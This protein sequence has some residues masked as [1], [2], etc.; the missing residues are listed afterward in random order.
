MIEMTEEFT[1]FDV[2]QEMIVKTAGTLAG[3]RAPSFYEKYYGIP[4]RSSL[5][6]TSIESNIQL[7]VQLLYEVQTLLTEVR[8]LRE[9]LVNRPLVSSILLN[10]LSNNELTI[11]SPISVIIEETNEECLARW[12]EVNAFGI[13]TTLS[14]AIHNL[15]DN[16]S[17]LYLDLTRR[18]QESLGEIALETLGILTSH[19]TGGR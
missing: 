9:E 19:I 17:D 3:T 5:Q 18:D 11:I 10:N 2:Y 15:K 6:I 1:D 16:I 14:E 7:T 4:T 13:G 12:L 8:S